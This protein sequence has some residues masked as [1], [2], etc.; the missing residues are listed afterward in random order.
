MSLYNVHVSYGLS[1]TAKLLTELLVSLLLSTNKR[2]TVF[3]K[4]TCMHLNASLQ[5]SS[6]IMKRVQNFSSINISLTVT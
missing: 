6:N 1:T 2:P 5:F 3:Y 4:K